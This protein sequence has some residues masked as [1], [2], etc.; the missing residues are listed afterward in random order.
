MQNTVMIEIYCQY[1]PAS[2]VVTVSL[3][4]NLTM[5]L[6]DILQKEATNVKYAKHSH[7]RNDKLEG[8]H[9]HS[10]YIWRDSLLRCLR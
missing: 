6:F 8:I 1:D 4:R 5:K 3:R 2:D 9:G 10:Q 7:L